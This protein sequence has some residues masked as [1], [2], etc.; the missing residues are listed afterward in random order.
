M[1][2]GGAGSTSV[3]WEWRD[4][5]DWQEYDPMT[6][7]FIEQL[8]QQ[9]RPDDVQLGQ[10]SRILRDYTVN[11]STM[12]QT[13]L[14][15]GKRRT[16]RRS[17]KSNTAGASDYIWEWEEFG[18]WTSYPS[19]DC[20]KLTA[21]Q[22][23][24]QSS[25]QLS[26][27]YT[28]DFTTMQQTNNF[29][30]YQRSVR[31]KKQPTPA[32]G[33]RNLGKSSSYS[34]MS[35]MNLRTRTSSAKNQLSV[36]LPSVPTN[37]IASTSANS[38]SVGA[39][40]SSRAPSSLN[41]T[42]FPQHADNS[43]DEDANCSQ[44]GMIVVAAKKLKSTS[45]EKTL[46]EMKVFNNLDEKMAANL[47][48]YIPPEASQ[49]D[50]DN[51]PICLLDFD[52]VYEDLP[53]EDKRANKV[54]TTVAVRLPCKHP[55]HLDCTKEIFKNNNKQFLTCPICKKVFGGVMT[56]TQPEGGTMSYSVIPLSC[57]GYESCSSYQ[58]IYN[59]PR[60]GQQLVK[61]L[62]VAFDRRLVFT[63][64]TSHT[65][66]QPDSVV[67]GGVH[68]KTSQNGGAHGFP[69]PFHLISLRDELNALNVTEAD[70]Q[71]S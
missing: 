71:L 29:T 61:M 11:V 60:N 3:C 14:L 56:G 16:I 53:D 1:A 38:S 20:A 34:G 33:A 7:N 22:A 47:R 59:F 58:I 17:I 63:I 64:G 28:I 15:T 31:R 50:K 32:M 21:A 67:W 46:A 27:K 54:P 24:G 49:D 2:V 70:T 35:H 48:F 23:A 12:V 42:V 65:T 4:D 19:S 68:H 41:V 51:C 57:A 39:L 26:P 45:V 6:S 43:E 40:S 36:A 66:G 13:R 37:A 55:L 10:I 62:K 69:D 30:S 44:H 25:C 5:Y 9:Q 8:Y 18:S 52:D